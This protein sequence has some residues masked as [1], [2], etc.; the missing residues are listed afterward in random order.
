LFSRESEEEGM[1][2]DRWGGEDLGEDAGGKA[3]LRIYCMVKFILKFKN[4]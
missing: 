1:E 3:L 2:F 4:P